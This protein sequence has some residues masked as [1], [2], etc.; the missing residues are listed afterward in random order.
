MGPSFGHAFMA[1]LQELGIEVIYGASW[2]YDQRY[3]HGGKPEGTQRLAAGEKDIPLSIG[4]QQ[5]YEV[6]NILNRL[7][8]DLYF[9]RHPGTSVWAAKLGI[10]AIPVVEEYSAFGYQGLVNFGWRIH[11]AL[12]NKRFITSLAQKVRLPYAEW[13]Y[14]QD[15]YTF[16]EKEAV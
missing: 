1:V 2:H 10:T 9:S 11:D 15:P 5:N 8:P 13:W 3:D 14:E 16:L 7:K 6:I 4:D 12:T